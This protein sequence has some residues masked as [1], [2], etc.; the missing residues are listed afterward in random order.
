MREVFVITTRRI[1]KHRAKSADHEDL[2]VL[3]IYESGVNKER[4]KRMNDYSKRHYVLV[5][6]NDEY[7]WK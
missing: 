3:T 1:S 5:N 7:D 2:T 4:V 6:Y